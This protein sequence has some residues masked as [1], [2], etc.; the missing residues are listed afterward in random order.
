MS[1]PIDITISPTSPLPYAPRGRWR[2]G[3][4]R[5]YIVGGVVAA[6]A[7]VAWRWGGDAARVAETVYWSRQCLRYAPPADLV[8]FEQDAQGIARLM[9]SGAGYHVS[10]AGEAD[11]PHAWLSPAPYAYIPQSGW[12]PYVAFMHARQ[13]ADGPER[14]V[15]IEFLAMREPRGSDHTV[16]F[17]PRVFAAS[18]LRPGKQVR[19]HDDTVRIRLGPDER[20]RLYAGQPDPADPS[21]FTIDCVVAGERGTIEGRLLADDV[22]TF[23]PIAGEALKRRWRPWDRATTEPWWD[24]RPPGDT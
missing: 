2:W 4:P 1:Q 22:V 14:L 8:V 3:L 6:L 10:N 12:E 20:L 18:M 15:V 7:I 19:R 5:R 21:R 23:R 11:P 9:G 16:L 13:S 24:S 17:H